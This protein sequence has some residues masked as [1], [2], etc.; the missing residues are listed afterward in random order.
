MPF[1]SKAQQGFM[2]AAES[3]GE[4][5]A[6]TAERWAHE[7]PDMKDLPERVS[8]PKKAAFKELKNRYGGKRK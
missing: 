1:K 7:T 5:K 2:F 8:G 6:G 4:I 3:R